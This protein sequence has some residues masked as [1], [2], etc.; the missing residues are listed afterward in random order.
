MPTPAASAQSL[1]LRSLG[2][3]TLRQGDNDKNHVWGGRAQPDVSGT[4]IQDLQT[5]LI[6]VGTLTASADGQFG[7]QT[8][9][10]LRRFQW[11]VAHLRHRLKLAPGALAAT[12]TIS[13]YPQP[14]NIALGICDAGTADLLLSWQSDHFVT[15]SPLVRLSLDAVSNIQTSDTFQVLAYPSAQEREVLVHADFAS[16]I[17]C[18]MNEE[19]KKANVTLRINQTFRRED[20]L[21]TGAIVSPAKKSQHLAGHAV[22]LNIVDGGTINSSAMFNAGTETAGADTFVDAVK[23]KGLR[24]GGDFHPA[25][26]V[27]F[28]D[29]LE[30]DSEDFSM[31]LF[32]AQR[33]FHQN[34]PMRQ[35]A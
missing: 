6:A 13:Q 21:P 10:A 19:A 22:D 31:T 27:H 7:A 15:T 8:Q 11:Y 26:P 12:G 9:M 23:A 28:D 20:I 14:G 30:P 34:H 17:S 2:A 3:L 33:C 32:F 18:V 16:T 25:D 4:P 35:V 5:V 29:F 1:N 24:W